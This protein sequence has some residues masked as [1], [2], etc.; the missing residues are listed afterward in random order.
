[1]LVGGVSTGNV[2]TNPCASWL[3]TESW[4]QLYLLERGKVGSFDGLCEDLTCNEADWKAVYDSSEPHRQTLPN[5]WEKELS[6]FEHLC[7]LRC[8]RLDKLIPGLRD[9]VGKNLGEEYVDPPTFDLTECFADSSVRVPLVFVLSA[10]SDPMSAL[11]RFAE[12]AH[13]KLHS[14]SL[15][16]GQGPHAEN[17]IEQ[18]KLH[19]FWETWHFFF[20]F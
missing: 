4:N 19:M 6:P 5:K 10:G 17:L 18:G 9:F 20:F 8:I 3:P 11:S 2:P 16:Q 13:M 14:L 7:V 15:G 12:R 1:M